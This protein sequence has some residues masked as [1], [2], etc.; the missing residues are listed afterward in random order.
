LRIGTP[1]AFCDD[2]RGADVWQARNAHDLP[3]VALYEIGTDQLIARP[4]ISL[5]VDGWADGLNQRV[6]VALEGDDAAGY[7]RNDGESTRLPVVYRPAFALE[8][9]GARI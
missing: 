3:A 2:T 5:D 8:A 1:R 4:V 7:A 6:G 9:L